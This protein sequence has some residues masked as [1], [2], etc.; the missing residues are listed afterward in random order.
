MYSLYVKNG[1]VIYL[2][3]LTREIERIRVKMVQL[4][5][6]FG[7]HHPDVQQC[8]RQLDY[9]LMQY[10]KIEKSPKHSLQLNNREITQ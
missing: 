6:H 3:D 7:F 2:M 9:L 10:Y 8:S 5:N 4:G 1:K